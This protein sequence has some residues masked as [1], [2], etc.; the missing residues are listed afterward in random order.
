MRAARQCRGR[1]ARRG[2]GGGFKAPTHLVDDGVSR[3]G[4]DLDDTVDDHLLLGIAKAAANRTRGRGDPD[5]YQSSRSPLSTGATQ[6]GPQATKGGMRTVRAA[7]SWRCLRR[8]ASSPPPAWGSWEACSLGPPSRQRPARERVGVRGT[9]HTLGYTVASGV[10]G[11]GPEARLD[12]G[13][14]FC[15]GYPWHRDGR[16]G[17]QIVGR[18]NANRCRYKRKSVTTKRRIFSCRLDRSCCRRSLAYCK[19]PC[20]R[21]CDL[22]WEAECRVARLP[23]ILRSVTTGFVS[24]HRGGSLWASLNRGRLPHGCVDCNVSMVCAVF[25]VLIGAETFNW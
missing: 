6:P 4:R 24:W 22:N 11:S 16:C 23:W 19:R 8:C 21:R 20:M 9:G 3:A 2:H 25:S 17:Q 13:T 15:H 18:E 1:V 5:C 10:A 12:D 7:R 14:P